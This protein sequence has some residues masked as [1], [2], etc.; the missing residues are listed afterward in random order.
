MAPR[1]SAE[2]H[3]R[4]PEWGP[5]PQPCGS[6]EFRGEKHP[7]DYAP[8]VLY[9]E[10]VRHA[11]AH[12]LV[13]A[14]ERSASH[15]HVVLLRQ[16]TK[17]V[18]LHD[19]QLV[20]GLD[21]VRRLEAAGKPFV[22]M[23]LTNDHLPSSE[24]DHDRVLQWERA[25]CTGSAWNAIFIGPPG[26]NMLEGPRK[27]WFCQQSEMLA[28]ETGNP[29]NRFTLPCATRQT[30]YNGTM[31]G[32]AFEALLSHPAALVKAKS[33]SA[34]RF[35]TRVTATKAVVANGV[36][37]S[38]PK[39]ARE[40]TGTPRSVATSLQRAN[41]LL[42]QYLDPPLL[43]HG[44]HL[45]VPVRT[46]IEARMHGLVQWEPLRIWV[47]PQVAT[48]KRRATPPCHTGS[49]HRRSRTQ[50]PRRPTRPTGRPGRP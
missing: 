40:L 36:G 15:G 49:A 3:R 37:L 26:K 39:T 9:P 11:M 32:S 7:T 28:W 45:G 16:L 6:R 34:P 14:G 50:R 38:T 30:P 29:W 25:N 44:V 24:K 42:M 35:L 10:Q 31:Y 13:L 41:L 1:G 46:R 20:G 22:M 48:G 12:T 4:P 21:S 47:A 23:T 18:G 5:E 27:A 17:L 19:P 2:W 43:A 33:P 8:W